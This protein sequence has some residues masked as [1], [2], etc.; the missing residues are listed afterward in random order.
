MAEWFVVASGSLMG[1]MRKFGR[2]L[3]PR[4]RRRA[5]KLSINAELEYLRRRDS[6]LTGVLDNSMTLVY[7]QDLAGR[8]LL[9]NQTFAETI[10]LDE[11]ASREGKNAS[12]LLIGHDDSWLG[13]ELAL[14]W[15]ERRL[16]AERGPYRVEDEFEIP[17]LGQGTFDTI[18]F[19]LRDRS[20]A[21]Y[22][23]CGVSL[24]VTDR[25]DAFEALS[26]LALALE[27]RERHFRLIAD[28]TTDLVYFVDL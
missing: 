9:Y 3:L 27:E 20:G 6:L 25:A 5:K 15:R 26:V 10:G 1:G 22:A 8:Y 4:P 21:V 16:R 2:W 18:S 19:P 12:E 17:G 24:D 11:R 14:R 23:T 28:N 7:V 13:P